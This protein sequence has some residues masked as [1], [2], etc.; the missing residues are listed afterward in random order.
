MEALLE[1]EGKVEN[2]NDDRLDELNQT[3]KEGF[4]KSDRE[5][6]E[7][8]ARLEHGM[9]E[10]FERVDKRFEQV[11]KRFEQVDKRFEQVDKRFEK[12]EDRFFKLMIAMLLIG[13]GMI[14][15]L[16]AAQI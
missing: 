4:A 16:I 11:D 5:M 15:A 13:G 10:A 3:M 1:R 2:W 12:L 8:F 9:K 6:K 7:G 14:S